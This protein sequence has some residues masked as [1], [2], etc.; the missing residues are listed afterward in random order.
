M[1]FINVDRLLS[2]TGSLI[3]HNLYCYCFNNPIFFFDSNGSYPQSHFHNMVCKAISDNS[4]GSIIYQG[5]RITYIGGRI[6][7]ADLIDPAA[8]KVWEVKRVTHS[9]PKALRQLA[10]YIGKGGQYHWSYA[11]GIWGKITLS[12]G[13]NR[14]V[15]N[16]CIL[17][18]NFFLMYGY[19]AEGI[20]PYD[21]VYLNNVTS[22]E[23]AKQRTTSRMGKASRRYASAQAIT[24]LAAALAVPIPF[25]FLQWS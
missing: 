3:S 14:P 23:E 11:E 17:D 25:I 20:V 13:E 21:Y 6:G 18:E 16:G 9:A 22:E 15:L 7:F 4:N 19:A 2:N 8:W 24:A 1:R 10:R 12:K 5:T